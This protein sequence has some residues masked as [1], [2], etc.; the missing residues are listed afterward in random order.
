MPAI[1]D[2]SFAYESVT[3]DAGLT[4]PICA[5]EENDLL[6]AICVGDTGTPTWGCS[7]GVG[8]WNNLFNRN[9]SCS[10][11]VYWKYA[12]ASGE[13]DVAFTSTVNETYSG[14]VVAIRDAYQS[15]TGGSP[16]L[17]TNTTSTGTAIALPT[18]TTSDSNSLVLTLVTSTA[19]APSIH[20]VNSVLQEENKVDGSAEGLGLG[21]FFKRSTGVTTAYTASAMVSGSGTKAVIEIRQPSGGA[22]V[23][24]PYPSSDDSIYITPSFGIAYDGNSAIAA[25]ADTNWG[26]TLAGKTANDATVATA[27]VDIGNDKGSFMSFSGVT[28]AA[29]ANQ[30]SGAE[31]VVAASRYNVGERNILTHF[32][33]ATPVQNQRLSTLGSGRGV[34][35]GM[36]SGTTAGQNYKIWQVHGSD[37]ATPPG[38][39][40]PIVINASNTDTVDSN[41]TITNSD[42]RR[43]GIWTGGLG[44][45]TQQVAFGP[46]WAMDTFALVGGNSTEPIDIPAIVKSAANNK[47]RYSSILQGSSQMLCLQAIQFGDGGTNPLYLSLDSTAIEF[48]SQKNYSKKIVNY[49]GIDNTVGFTYYAGATDTVIHRSSVISSQSKYHWR[50][51]SSSSAS[52]IYD[53]SGLTIIGAGD[54]QLR[55]VTTFNGMTFTTCPTITQNSAVIDDCTFSNSKI[56][57][58]TLGDLDNISNCTFISSGTGHAIEVSGAASTISFVGNSFTGFASSNG[59]T[60]NEAIYVN[61][62]SGIVTLNISGGGSTPSIRTAGATV[63]INNTVDITITVVDKNNNPIENAQTAV[64]KSIDDTQLM[65]EDTNA[66]G[67]ATEDFNYVSNTSIYI[68]VR[69]ASSGG[70]KYIPTSS[71]GTI[72]NEGFSTTI[73][74][75][76]DP[77]A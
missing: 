63:N 10:T 17:Q 12:A 73:I 59:S 7:N 56:T 76:E 16:M 14:I 33:H 43:Y 20:F 51:H 54:V 13:G 15:Y 53:F 11:T 58:A 8:S 27:V 69:K 49:N 77:N 64:F 41:S 50:I 4:I 60:G 71:T 21:W 30:V 37:V 40:V 57:S 35:F 52:A 9:N 6:I 55:A 68:R 45:L 18:L 5:Y 62:A 39:V 29:T 19:A 38:S 48:P 26:T 24:P 66:S 70:P 72:T 32:R 61:I 22:T 74:L 23:I 36:K 46:T 25:T 28:N 67:I 3:T 34:W 44:V 42:I 75:T 47:N 65:N 2:S 1:R 31:G